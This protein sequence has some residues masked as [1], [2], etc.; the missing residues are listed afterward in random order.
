VGLTDIE[1]Y[2]PT[3][4]CIEQVTLLPEDKHRQAYLFLDALL[5][6]FKAGEVYA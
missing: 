6:D 3:L 4:E 1:L 5:L 2:H